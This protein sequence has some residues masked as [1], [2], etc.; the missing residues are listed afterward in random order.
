MPANCGSALEV[1][2]GN[3]VKLLGVRITACAELDANNKIITSYC[4]MLCMGL[5]G[6]PL[7]N[8]PINKFYSINDFSQTFGVI[9]PDPP[10]LSTTAK[11]EGHG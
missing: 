11:L 10:F 3:S 2:P 7:F 6:D 4:Q 9:Q 1:V 5:G 8:N